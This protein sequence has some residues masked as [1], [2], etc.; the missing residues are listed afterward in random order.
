MVDDLQT[1]EAEALLKIIKF[2]DT[3]SGW[4]WAEEVAGVATCAFGVTDS[5]GRRIQGVTAELYVKY[6]S[7]PPSTHF[8]FTIFKKEYRLR[9]RVYQLDILQ[10]GRKRRDAHGLPHE[11]VGQERRP[12]GLDWVDFRYSDAL[13]LFCART[14]LCLVPELPDPFELVLS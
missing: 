6:G 14:N 8:M 11:H 1:D 5:D 9:R 10:N 12:G 4:E 13:Q 3:T 2:G 7:R